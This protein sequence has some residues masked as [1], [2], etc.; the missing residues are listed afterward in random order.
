MKP[1]DT[2]P[3]KNG[4]GPIHVNRFRVAFR[5]PHPAQ[6]EQ[7]ARDFAAALPGFMDPQTAT[8]ELD[9]T[10]LYDGR[11]TLCFHGVALVRLFDVPYLALPIGPGGTI[12]TVPVP[13]QLRHLTLPKV[14]VD[15]VG[16]IDP[17]ASG[18]ARTG[19]APMGITV[20]TLNRYFERKED[21]DVRRLVGD[22]IDKAA[23]G[24]AL[25]P[26]LL[27]A[28]ITLEMMKGAIQDYAVE[29]NRH[30]FLAGRRSFRLD[31]AARFHHKGPADL[32][33]F[34]TAAVERF[35]RAEFQHVTDTLLGGDKLALGLIWRQMCRKL[36]AAFPGQQPISAADTREGP[37]Y[38][39]RDGQ[40]LYV[41]EDV[42]N[43]AG[44]P[45]WLEK[46]G[47]YHPALFDPR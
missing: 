45:A 2:Q 42:A 27:S 31:R 26:V 15:Y 1:F 28:A 5:A 33:V 44:V 39:Q 36:G 46:A 16:V 24:A 34:E 32:W 9:T 21:N 18:P 22:A 41:Q 8:T 37:T 47:G 29:V 6:A 40:I 30:H 4:V 7:V 10:Y 35:A 13:D 20:Q 23:L 17:P 11:S 25:V 3:I 12:V 14:H 43:L 38:W 19:E